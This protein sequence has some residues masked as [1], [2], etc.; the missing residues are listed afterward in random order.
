MAGEFPQGWGAA[1]SASLL[2]LRDTLVDVERR[3]SL[4]PIDSMRTR[5]RARQTH[6]RRSKPRLQ[7]PTP[8]RIARASRVESKLSKRHLLGEDLFRDVLVR[9]WKRAERFA[10]PFVLLLVE[11]VDPE[12]NGQTG[13]READSV[14]SRAIGALTASTRHTDVMGW[15][16]EGVVLGVILTEIGQS[17]AEAAELANVIRRQLAT[18]LDADVLDRLELRLHAH[19][20]AQ[21]QASGPEGPRPADP[22][23]LELCAPRNPSSVREAIKRGLDILGSALLLAMLSPLF[24]VIAILVKLKSPGPIFFRQD[25][26]GQGAKPFTMFKFRT[27]HIDADRSLHHEF[28]TRFIQSSGQAQ[29]LGEN[30]LFKIKNDPRV[31]PIG[32]ILRRT[33]LDEL[34]QFWNVLRG[35]MSL[36]GPRPPLAYELEQYRSWHWRRVLEA[37]PGITGLWQVVGRSRTSFDEMVRLDL[38]YVRTCSLTTDIKILLATPRAVVSGKGAC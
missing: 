8:G 37:K 6:P 30:D 12:S 25:R 11:L 10:E 4:P 18:R 23:L 32:R 22:L 33:S 34:P 7:P 9:E 29:E 1:L 3:P 16:E 27:M 5:F 20:H 28:V 26:I 38:R 24:L 14:W 13:A 31:T 36:V 19:A 2:T 35:D 21:Q 17:D 15:F